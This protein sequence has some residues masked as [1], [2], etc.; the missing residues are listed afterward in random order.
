MSQGAVERIRPQESIV[1]VFAADDEY[2][3]RHFLGTGFIFGNE[4]LLA[5][6]DHVV[7]GWEGPIRVAIPVLSKT[8]WVFT[9]T[10]LALD[11]EA[12]LALFRVPDYPTRSSIQLAEDHEILNNQIVTCLE[13]STFQPQ[14]VK[15]DLLGGSL[16]LV[17]ATRLGNVT[18]LLDRSG[19]LGRAGVDMLE[20]SFPAL[21]GASGAPILRVSDEGMHLW[22]IV[23]ANVSYELLPAQILTFV[24][25]RNHT[26][27]EIRY[28]LPQAVAVHVK[29]LRAMLQELSP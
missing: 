7:R 19:D 27:E 17:P 21:Q 10:P 18:R 2:R 11:R 12:D 16:E 3:I 28:Y 1:A 5:T 13:Y 22:G 25:E 23:V 29:H 24:D 20:L 15:Y 9:A 8:R 4:P 6:A 14:G 26:T